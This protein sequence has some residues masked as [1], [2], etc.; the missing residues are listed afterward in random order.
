MLSPPALDACFAAVPYGYPWAELIV[1]FKFGQQAGRCASLAL[2]LRSAPWVEPALD[3]ADIII[4]MPLSP[5]RLCERGYNQACLIARELSEPKTRADL[6]LRIQD[7]AHQSQL[8]RSERLRNVKNAFAI[9]P[10][11]AERIK[12]QRVVLVDDV[13]TTGASLH[14]AALALRAAGA[15]HITG[16]VVA[17]TGN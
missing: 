3:E 17:R 1:D 4:P 10:L 6:L 8:S 2:L 13:M 16:L 12:D 9:N 14:A 5:Q 7:V 11:A 15:K